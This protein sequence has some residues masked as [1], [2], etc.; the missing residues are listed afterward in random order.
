MKVGKLP[1]EIKMD[2]QVFEALASETR[3]GLLKKLD[4]QQMTISELSREMDMAKSTVHEHLVKMVSSGLVDKF[5]NGHKW[6]YYH[7]TSKGRNILHPHETAK[8][9]VFLG[10]SVLAIASGITNVLNVL[11]MSGAAAPVAE[12]ALMSEAAAPGYGEVPTDSEMAA[13]S[14]A[15]R[16]VEPAVSAAEPS[17]LIGVVLIAC[18]IAL[19]YIAYRMWKR[20]RPKKFKQNAR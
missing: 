11:T 6:T 10:V 5:D 19:A 15:P 2:R 4:S 8:I 9:M 20:R 14:E 7:L 17:M 16:A 18:G 13:L 12:K 3:I 1:D